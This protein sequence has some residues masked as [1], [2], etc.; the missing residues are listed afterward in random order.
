MKENLKNAIHGLDYEISKKYP[1]RM[2]LFR[3]LCGTIMRMCD[4]EELLRT[5][6]GTIDSCLK[7]QI[8]PFFLFDLGMN[9]GDIVKKELSEI[10]QKQGSETMSQNS[11]F[12]SGDKKMEFSLIYQKSLCLNCSVDNLL[13]DYYL[14]LHAMNFDE[15]RYQALRRQYYRFVRRVYPEKVVSDVLAQLNLPAIKFIAGYPSFGQLNEL[16]DVA[17]N[18]RTEHIF[19]IFLDE[20]VA[21][22]VYEKSKKRYLLGVG[23][24]LKKELKES[25]SLYKKTLDKWKKEGILSDINGDPDHYQLLKTVEVSSPSHAASLVKGVNISGTKVWINRMGKSLKDVL[26]TEREKEN[27]SRL[28]Y[29]EARKRKRKKAQKGRVPP[30]Q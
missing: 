17:R 8:D 14:R 19:Y 4:G 18:E 3:S 20:G 25:A 12:L 30:E 5:F 2:T 21:T 29:N 23:S 16:C 13:R 22:L 27:S 28:K 11:T 1:Q 15:K 9:L 26:K 6:I 24:L 10:S 7:N